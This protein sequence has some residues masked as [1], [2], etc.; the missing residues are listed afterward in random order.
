MRRHLITLLALISGL[1][2]IQAPANASVL[3][4]FVFDARAL[5]RS[6]D[7]SASENCSCAQQREKQASRCPAREKE[8]PPVRLPLGLRPPVI[9]GS[10]RALE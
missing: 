3:E 5:A 1:A 7:S 2:A 8:T 10:E 9:F 6:N 4:S